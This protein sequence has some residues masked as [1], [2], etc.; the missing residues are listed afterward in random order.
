[1]MQWISLLNH[2]KC[3]IQCAQA[4]M[5]AA[6]QWL[7]MRDR[8]AQVACITSAQSYVQKPAWLEQ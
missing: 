3:R 6:L 1:M 2:R 7:V 5:A 8:T 4:N